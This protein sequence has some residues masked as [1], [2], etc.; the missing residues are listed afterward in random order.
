MNYV[1]SLIRD[2]PDFPKKGIVFK[3]IT[4][5]LASSKAFVQVIDWYT[6]MCADVDVI[7]G[8]DAR[9]F[10]FGGAAAYALDKPF[11]PIRKKG[12]VPFKTISVSYDLEY[13]Q[14]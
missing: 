4:P 6:I 13:G 5:V 14:E 12:K 10:I 9:G 1:R 11:V 2:I 8:V 7:A 3:D